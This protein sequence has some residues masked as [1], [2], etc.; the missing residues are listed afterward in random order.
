MKRAH[1]MNL[2]AL[3]VLSTSLLAYVAFHLLPI[4][5]SMDPELEERG[6]ELWKAVY[7]FIKEPDASYSREMI[8]VAGFLSSAFLI[9]ACPFLVPVLNRSRWLWW[10]MVLASGAAM[11]GLGGI[12][13]L[14]LMDME[15]PGSGTCC[16]LAA[17]VLNFLGLLFI[18]RE[19]APE[20]QPAWDAQA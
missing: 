15:E 2:V 7:E 8:G 9:V 16:L 20:I 10:V 18:R 1:W 12:V 3:A 5:A 17:L 13:L 6:W 14:A 19:T 4:E 11:C